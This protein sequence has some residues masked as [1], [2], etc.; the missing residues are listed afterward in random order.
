MAEL[1]DMGEFGDWA[2]VFE[3]LSDEVV[4]D[5]NTVCV[6]VISM[7][8]G[9]GSLNDLVLYKD[10]QPLRKE[11]DELDALRSKLYALCHE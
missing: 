11:N 3:R 4:V 6:D 8:G 5:P 1:L 9:M 7:Y 2:L 10:G